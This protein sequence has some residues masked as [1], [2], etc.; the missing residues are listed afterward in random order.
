MKFATVLVAY[1]YACASAFA[2]PAFHQSTNPTAPAFA[3]SNEVGA[4][5]L[6]TNEPAGNMVIAGS[7]SSN[8]KV[9]FKEAI[10]TRGLGAHITSNGDPD[11]LQS[12]GS[13]KA[14]ATG[15]FLVAVNAGSSTV[16][17]FKINPQDPTSLQQV[18]QPVSSG[19]EF[20]VSAAINKK[21]TQVCVLN[22]G[23]VN[24]VNCYT[25]DKNLGLIRQADTLRSLNLASDDG[26][27]VSAAHQVAFNDANDKL[28][29]T[30]AGAPGSIAVFDVSSSGALSQ[31]FTTITP[32]GAGTNGPFS[33][34]AL[35]GKNAMLSADVNLGLDVFDLSSVSASNVTGATNQTVAASGQSTSLAL[36]G[37]K[38]TCWSSFSSKTGNFYLS[39]AGSSVLTEINLDQNLKPTVVKQYPQTNGSATLD[40]D[41]A[42]L[43]NKDFLYVLAAGKTA[44]DVLSLDGPGDANS[45]GSFEF[46]SIAKASGLTVNAANVQGMTTFVKA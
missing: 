38:A 7:L 6:I 31:S 27:S 28:I 2:L 5:Y 3:S 25:V 46:A 18:G 43:G 29:V 8:G 17:M 35:A 16:S 9:A 34:T 12:Q 32:P 23:L 14:S 24:G 30:V 45:V 40:S 26:P 15:G 42:K 1:V 22:A 36:D 44:I 20:P 33:L 19:G 41:V 39:D 21:G 10:S 13:I 37:Q 4:V 11:G